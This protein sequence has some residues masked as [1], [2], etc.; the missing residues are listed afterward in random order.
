MRYTRLGYV[1]G[2][3]IGVGGDPGGSCSS[4]FRSDESDILPADGSRNC[5]TVSIALSSVVNE[6]LVSSGAAGDLLAC[7]A[8]LGGYAY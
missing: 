7:S 1:P 5:P 3:V 2:N 8:G 4:E 6:A